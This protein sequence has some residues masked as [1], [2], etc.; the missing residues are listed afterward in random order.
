MLKRLP[1]TGESLWTLR[2]ER[3]KYWLLVAL[4]PVVSL[5][6][7]SVLALT[8][9]WVELGGGLGTTAS[10]VILTGGFVALVLSAIGLPIGLWRDSRHVR[11]QQ[12]DWD[13]PSSL[14]TGLGVAGILLP[15][16]A[17]PVA[18]AY[19]HFR[20]IHTDVGPPRLYYL[21]VPRPFHRYLPQ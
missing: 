18:I 15:L 9:T 4:K 21:V 7:M 19:L 3:D 10:Q 8:A 13:P 2:L 11:A 1:L 16:L 6:V 17:D 12:L 14:F 20:C 5:G